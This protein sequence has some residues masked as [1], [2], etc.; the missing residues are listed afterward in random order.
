M[1][2]RLHLLFVM[3]IRISRVWKHPRKGSKKL[4][5][6]FILRPPFLSALSFAYSR[7]IKCSLF[8]SAGAIS[9]AVYDIAL[10]R[11]ATKVVQ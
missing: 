9:S 11:L 7:C 4:N 1:N 5:I 3:A 2:A 6:T 8:E 10:A